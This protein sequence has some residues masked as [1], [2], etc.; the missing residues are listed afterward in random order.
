MSIQQ[1]LD[2]KWFDKFGHLVS[3]DGDTSTE[4]QE[5]LHSRDSSLKNYIVERITYED[6]DREMS[7]TECREMILNLIKNL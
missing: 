7:A 6:Y 2:E 1:E 3:F 5:M 4:M